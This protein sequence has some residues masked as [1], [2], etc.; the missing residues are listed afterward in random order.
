MKIF[1]IIFIVIILIITG[2]NLYIVSRLGYPYV[3]DF[4]F[5]EPKKIPYKIG[6]VV[7]PLGRLDF[8]KGVWVAYIYIHYEDY[9]DLHR[10]IPK[11][12]LLK[13][14]DI[15]LFKQMKRDWKFRYT[16]S[17]VATVQSQI[18]FYCDGK[19]V[20]ES[21]ICLDDYLQCLQSRYFGCIKGP[22][23]VKSCRQFEKTYFP[24]ITF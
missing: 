5:E 4:D 17:D 11:W 14:T 18:I 6:D 16:G 8:D 7:R 19:R 3:I 23:L 2:L 21:G 12:G 13:S 1:R 24:V 10:S 9:S 15:K 22:N 20:F